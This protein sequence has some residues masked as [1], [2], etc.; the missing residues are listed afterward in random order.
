MVISGFSRP[1]GSKFRL[2]APLIL[3]HRLII[4]HHHLTLLRTL[5][6]HSP[7]SIHV[8]TH[9]CENGNQDLPT[10]AHIGFPC[11]IQTSSSLEQ[12]SACTQ[13]CQPR[14]SRRQSS[15]ILPARQQ[16]YPYYRLCEFITQSSGAVCS[17]A[18]SFFR[19][20]R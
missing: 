6:S 12:P 15:T 14:R 8:R 20:H 19:F 3:N 16:L 17:L 9:S 4:T 7:G 5:L 1:S 10:A 11:I 18:L 2:T 13:R